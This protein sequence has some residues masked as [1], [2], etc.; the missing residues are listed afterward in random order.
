ML[1]MPSS[2]LLRLAGL[3]AVLGGVLFVLVSIG[4]VV[5]L[6]LAPGPEGF[7][8]AAL[9]LFFIQ[10]ASALLG[11]VL[12]ALGLIGLYIY[13]SEATDHV[14][15]IGFLMAFL[16]TTLMQGIVWAALLA[17]LGWALFGVATLQ[18]GF[19]PR[20]A[21]ILLIIGAATS[22]VATAYTMV[23]FG[24]SSLVYTGSGAGIILNAAIAWLGFILFKR[25]ND[26]GVQH[27][28]Q[29]SSST[30]LQSGG[31][32]AAL[33]GTLVTVFDL[34]LLVSTSLASGPGGFGGAANR[35]LFIVSLLAQLSQALLALGLVG[36][37]VRQSEAAGIIGLISFLMAF[38]GMVLG[39]GI[40]DVPGWAAPL[41]Y[42]GLALFGVV[43]LQA[44]IYPRTAAILLII[45]A[46]IA[47]LFSPLIITLTIGLDSSLAYVGASAVII[48]NVVITWLG[49]ILFKEEGEEASQTTRMS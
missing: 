29:A 17:Y 16:G 28:T 2:I 20:I 30:L 8:D 13:Q 27:P 9:I 26:A 25:R 21:A 23:G 39:L 43:T 33:G 5:L 10:P 4:D 49:Y 42:L 38:P 34:L 7:S 11:G 46:A 19:Y 48:F 36:L 40:E 35:T 15:L 47:G 3:A 22:G 32:A 44:S 1:L 6:S 18:A 41:A 37:Y 24:G 12:L 14:G 31:L 45:S